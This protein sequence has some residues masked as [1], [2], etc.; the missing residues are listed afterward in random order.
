LPSA[1]RSHLCLPWRLRLTRA[2]RVARD[3]FEASGAASVSVVTPFWPWTTTKPPAQAFR[4]S[5]GPPG[6]RSTVT[7]T[8]PLVASTTVSFGAVTASPGALAVPP[9]ER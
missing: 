1:H 9:G 8:V 6:L 5:S 7:L 2:V 4:L 3:A